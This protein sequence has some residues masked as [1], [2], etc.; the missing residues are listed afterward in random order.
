MEIYSSRSFE[1]P[2]S[3]KFPCWYTSM[4]VLVVIIFRQAS[5]VALYM[6]LNEHKFA[7]RRAHAQ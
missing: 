6:P 7:H 1:N 4:Y 3:H 2:G 5:Y